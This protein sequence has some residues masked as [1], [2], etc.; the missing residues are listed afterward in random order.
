MATSTSCPVVR[1]WLITEMTARLPAAVRISTREPLT[2][3][4]ESMWLGDSVGATSAPHGLGPATI[5]R[6]EEYDT[7]VV[8][9]CQVKLSDADA[10]TRV[11]ARFQELQELLSEDPKPSIDGLMHLILSSWVFTTEAPEGSPNVKIT[12]TIRAKDHLA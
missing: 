9:L 11:F 7:D 6:D 4:G 12:A 3:R 2:I 10:E 5:R 8:F 1:A